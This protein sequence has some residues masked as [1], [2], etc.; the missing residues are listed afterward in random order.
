[1]E[2][3]E[4]VVRTHK[5]ERRGM[6]RKVYRRD[7]NIQDVIDIITDPTKDYSK[8]KSHDSD[9]NAW[10]GSSWK[11][12]VDYV[13][14][15]WKQGVAKLDIKGINELREA[16]RPELVHDLVGSCVDV[17]R[18]LAGEPDNMMAVRF[19]QVPTPVVKIGVDKAVSGGVSERRIQ[20]LGKNILVLIE[21][22][23]MAGIPA[24]V[25]ACEAVSGRGNDVLD[26]R[27]KVQD[28][29]RPIDVSRLAYWVAHPS[30]LR[31]TLFC[32]AESEDSNIRDIF[33]IKRYGGYGMPY[34]DWAKDDFDEWAPSAQHDDAYVKNWIK[35]VLDRRTTGR[36]VG[37]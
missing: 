20:A 27:V 1:M 16:E 29:S 36:K 34:A 28:P 13:I 10:A 11:E 37:E 31:R 17:G 24:E 4:K 33:G 30:A 14:N 8:D 19:N 18:Y 15:G 35:E 5:V 32:V 25:W 7:Y 6:V 21:S 9:N 23:R 22:L 12:S 2:Q 26:Y 3:W